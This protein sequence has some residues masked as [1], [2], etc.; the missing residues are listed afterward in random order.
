M[1]SIKRYDL[2]QEG[3]YSQ[4]EGVMTEITNGDWVS[5]DDYDTLEEEVNRLRGLIKDA[6]DCAREALSNLDEA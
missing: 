1:T 2:R 3:D 6:R 5:A 4:R